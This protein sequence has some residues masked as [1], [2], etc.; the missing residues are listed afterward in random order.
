MSVSRK[1]AF[2]DNKTVRY[3]FWIFQ[4]KNFN[5]KTGF[6]LYNAAKCCKFQFFLICHHCNIKIHSTITNN[7]AYDNFELTVTTKLLEQK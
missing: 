6:L 1:N 4:K 5:A 3:S 2:R 7:K